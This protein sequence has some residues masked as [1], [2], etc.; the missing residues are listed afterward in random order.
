MLYQTTPV[1]GLDQEALNGCQEFLFPGRVEPLTWVFTSV[2]KSSKQ[3][4]DVPTLQMRI[5]RPRFVPG[6][7]AEK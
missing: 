3:S 7:T 1:G 2:I 5:L 4:H 6:H